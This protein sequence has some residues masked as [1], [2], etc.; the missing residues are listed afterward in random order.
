M[1]YGFGA[2]TRKNAV[3]GGVDRLTIGMQWGRFVD[4]TDGPWRAIVL[5]LGSSLLK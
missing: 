3:R 4:F 5:E 2:G 1:T